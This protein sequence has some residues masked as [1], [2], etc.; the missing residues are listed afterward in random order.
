GNNYSDEWKAEAMRRGLK[1]LRTLPA[2]ASCLLEDENVA[3]Q[4]VTPTPRWRAVWT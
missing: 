4:P 1:N 3:L 2:C